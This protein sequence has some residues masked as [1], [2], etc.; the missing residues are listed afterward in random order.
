MED[1]QEKYGGAL[2]TQDIRS[3]ARKVRRLG[4]FS[5]IMLPPEAIKITSALNSSRALQQMAGLGG[6]LV[7]LFRL[8]AAKP[9]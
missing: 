1:F 9:G 2:K 7:P 5:K 8:S 4:D 3:D 6:R